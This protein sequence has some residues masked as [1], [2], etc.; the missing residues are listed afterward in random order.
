MTVAAYALLLGAGVIA[1]PKLL[2]DPDADIGML[3]ATCGPALSFVAL[4][5]VLWTAFFGS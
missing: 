5:A 2:R 4:A 1:V 3:I